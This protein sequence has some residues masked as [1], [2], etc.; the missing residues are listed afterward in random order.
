VEDITTI[1]ENAKTTHLPVLKNMATSLEPPRGARK[2][3]KTG[4]KII[5]PYL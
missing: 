4:K 1:K 3:C 5:T 2:K